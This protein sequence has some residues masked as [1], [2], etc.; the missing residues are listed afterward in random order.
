MFGCCG[1]ILFDY[2]IIRM[3]I[4]CLITNSSPP[5]QNGLH[6]RTR[7]FQMHFREGTFWY[8]D[9]ML[10]KFVPKGRIDNNP[11]LG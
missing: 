9:Q 4:V 2:S 11:P 6:F 5:E 8:F 1:F 7:Y 10:L 3:I